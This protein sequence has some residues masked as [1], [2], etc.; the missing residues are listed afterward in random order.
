MN[1]K[2]LVALQFWAGDR[3]QTM[4]LARFLA[5]IEPTHSD[6]ADLLFAARFDCEHDMKT[7][8]YVSRKFN[9]RTFTSRRRGVGWPSGCNELW[10][11]VMEWAASMI[12]ARKIPNYKAIF[13]T[14]GDCCPIQRNWASL[15]SRCW[16][17]ETAKKRVVMAGPL[18]DPGP[19]ING[20]ALMS[21]DL[22]FFRWLSRRVSGVPA[23]VGWDYYLAPALK[24]MG[25]ADI[26]EMKSIYRTPTFSREQWED[27]VMNNWVWIHGVKDDSLIRIGRE[28]FLAKQ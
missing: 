25:W 20:N 14:E 22:K 2:I 7:V 3:A 26:P 13:T 27:M 18:V 1:R 21:T 10:F 5:D 15:L 17:R 23:R 6:Q 19:H 4:A 24:E 12:D 16:D 28:K 9:V 11:S 8:E